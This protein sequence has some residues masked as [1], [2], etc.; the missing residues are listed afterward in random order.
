MLKLTQV[1]LFGPKHCVMPPL[2]KLYLTGQ[3]QRMLTI[4]FASLSGSSISSV[5]ILCNIIV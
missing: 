1:C 3:K 5:I 2:S 4:M